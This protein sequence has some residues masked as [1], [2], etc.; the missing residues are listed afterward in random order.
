MNRRSESQLRL[1]VQ[2]PVT[3]HDRPGGWR[4]G[5]WLVRCHEENSR[6]TSPDY[7]TSLEGCAYHVD[8]Q[9]IPRSAGLPIVRE[10]PPGHVVC[11]SIGHATGTTLALSCSA[12]PVTA[13]TAQGMARVRSGQAPAWPLIADRRRH[14]GSAVTGGQRPFPKG[15]QSALT[16]EGCRRTISGP[17]PDPS[18]TAALNLPRSRPSWDLTLF[19]RARRGRCW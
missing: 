11:R 3:L 18:L 14:R 16:V 15:T 7:G 8:K 4:R 17:S 12:R 19:A 5:P 10:S 1:G 6:P 2:A 13:R 9:G